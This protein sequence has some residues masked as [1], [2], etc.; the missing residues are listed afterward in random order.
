M[1]EYINQSL[2]Y[3]ERVEHEAFLSLWSMVPGF[4]IGSAVLLGSVVSVFVLGRS[5]WQLVS[6]LLAGALVIAG[7]GL[8]V[9]TLAVYYTTE[10]A[11]TN[12]RVI[13]KRGWVSRSTV[14]LL[15]TKVESIQ[16]MQSA[17]QRI[18]GYGDIVISAA[19]EEN[20]M[21]SGISHPITFRDHYYAAEEN[22]KIAGAMHTPGVSV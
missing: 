10:L 2:R 20:A 22:S 4:V 18:L 5:D 8:L 6:Y 7:T 13:A 14:E 19:G 21:I 11:V 1:G 9:Q 15:L 3:G 12:K 17:V 16:V